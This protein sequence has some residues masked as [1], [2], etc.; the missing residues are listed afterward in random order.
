MSSASCCPA[1]CPTASVDLPAAGFADE[2]L[3]IALDN[4]FGR[5]WGR[6]ASAGATAAS[7]RWAC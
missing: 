7:S 3:E 1:S 2:L 6:E 4:V 5:L